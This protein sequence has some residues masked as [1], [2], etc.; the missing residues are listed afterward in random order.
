M[1][2]LRE[3]DGA[4]LQPCQQLTSDPAATVVGVDIAADDHQRTALDGLAAGPGRPH[5]DELAAGHA[6]RVSRA[7]SNRGDRNSSATCSGDTG[8]P[9]PS[10]VIAR[11]TSA[12][13][14]GTSAAVS[15]RQS[16]CTLPV[17]QPERVAAFRVELWTDPA[18]FLAAAR[19][20]LDALG[21]V[22]SVVRSTAERAATTS[23]SDAAPLPD[24]WYATVRGG[25]HTVVGAAMRTATFAP[26]PVYVLPMPDDG[27]L[28]LAAALGERGEAITAVNGFAP[29]AE[30][31]FSACTGRS[32]DDPGVEVERLRLHEVTRVVP[33]AQA[34]GRFRPPRPDEADLVRRWFDAFMRE[35][36]EQAGRPAGTT[37]TATLTV[38]E[39]NERA[40]AG[41]LWVWDVDGRP[42][43][44]TGVA[45]PA[46]GTARIGPVYTPPEE[47]GRGYASSAVGLLSERLLADGARVCLFTDLANPTSNAV[48]ERLGYVGVADAVQLWTTA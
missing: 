39:V 25:E 11:L 31:F 40:A 12:V 46:G 5:R 45:G 41:R 47:R 43:H 14:A 32:P 7:G 34:A 6:P 38:T 22:A 13:T 48:Y 2:L 24:A 37:P 18:A 16:I 42:V 35:A 33:P 21:I 10:A 1:P 29:A 26:Y 20:H 9:V 15:G 4:R 28:A 27:A 30:T 23:R 44:M 36:D 19:A 8:R 3:R 17:C